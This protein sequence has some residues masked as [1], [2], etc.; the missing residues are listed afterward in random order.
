M[1]RTRQGEFAWTDL[2]A[3]DLDGQ[4]AFYEGL[5][6][7]VRSDI[8]MPD[9]SVYRVWSLGGKSVAAA[10]AMPADMAAK[11]IPSM[12]NVYIAVND[13]DAS[14]A[15]AVE[16]GGTVAMSAT[17]MMGT[18]TGAIMDPTGAPV[19]LM[20]NT[21]PDP[22]VGYSEPGMLAWNDLSTRDPEK[23]A[24]FFTKLLGWVVKPMVAEEG[25]EPYW[26]IEIDGEGEGGIMPMPEMVPA[27]V[28]SYWLDYFAVTDI[29]TSAAKAKELG[30]MTLV[31]PTK[32]GEMLWFAVIADPAGATFSLLQTLSPM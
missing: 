31:E 2:Y 5:F 19:F 7:W 6:G 13:V 15:K 32:V 27:E 23:A 12:W 14:M 3:K 26:T 8:P 29:H 17:D 10:S 9:G 30:A 25:A 18:R 28:P 1:E 11:G 16:L 24:D 21:K 4:A 20:H 22:N